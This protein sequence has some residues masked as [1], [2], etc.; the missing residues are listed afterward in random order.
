[1]T[2]QTKNPETGERNCVSVVLIWS[3]DEF[4]K[5]RE[6]ALVIIRNA[7]GKIKECAE[8]SGNIVFESESTIEGNQA[9]L[10]LVF[11]TEKQA[12]NFNMAVNEIKRNLGKVF[13]RSFLYSEAEI[14]YK[15]DPALTE[16]NILQL[17][18]DGRV[19]NIF[20]HFLTCNVVSEEG[21]ILFRFNTLADT[22]LFLYNKSNASGMRVTGMIRQNQEPL[23]LLPD[24]DGMFSL[25][26]QR[27]EMQ[28]NEDCWSWRHLEEKFGFH[29]KHREQEMYFQFKNKLDLYTYFASEEAKK[30][31]TIKIPM[32][33][34]GNI[35]ELKI[36]EEKAIRNELLAVEAALIS[37]KVELAKKNKILESQNRIIAELRTEWKMKL[38]KRQS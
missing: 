17:A 10:D 26:V 34:I 12:K 27:I 20:R 6:N 15:Q 24:C 8:N 32:S 25:R 19:K 13:F 31:A 29:T 28:D 38:G 33:L 36:A 4:K 23:C 22:N 1:M 3:K 9:R 5:K 35:E 7:L 18:K 16:M 21:I 30:C 2:T 37:A 11:E 14:D